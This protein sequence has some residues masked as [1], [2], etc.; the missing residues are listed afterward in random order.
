MLIG[1]LGGG[2]RILSRRIDFWLVGE[3]GVGWTR[4]FTVGIGIDRV[5]HCTLQN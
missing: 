2:R 3:G 4:M 5:R 1:D